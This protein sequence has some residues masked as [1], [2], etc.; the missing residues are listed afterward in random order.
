M[1]LTTTVLVY[2]ANQ[3]SF[4]NKYFGFFFPQEVTYSCK[5]M[6]EPSATLVWYE[7][8]G[9]ALDIKVH[10][11]MLYSVFSISF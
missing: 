5:I 10:D 8:K 4:L 9:F 7:L 3:S 6:I 1:L 11:Q 2:N